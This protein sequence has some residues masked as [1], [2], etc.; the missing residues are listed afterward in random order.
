MAIRV[1]IT[2]EFPLQRLFTIHVR[3]YTYMFPLA[4]ALMTEKTRAL[5][6]LVFDKVIEVLRTTVGNGAITIINMV[7]DYEFAILNA[8]S[9]AFPRGTPRGCW[10]HFGQAIFRKVTRENL[11][12]AYI[13]RPN[14]KKIIM[15]LIA[16]ALLPAAQ[17]HDGFMHIQRESVALLVEETP[18]IR[19]KIQIIFEYM[20]RY[21]FDIVTPERFS[22][23]GQSSRTNNEV[24]CFHRWFNARCGKYHQSFWTFIEYLLGEN[25]VNVDTIFLFAIFLV[26]FTFS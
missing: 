9:A 3:A 13:N 26:V 10:F 6:T 7:S 12:E 5:Y 11:K 23:Y 1:S 4:Y 17:A 16:L 19:A 24:E 8:M 18:E 20:Q 22:V 21:W 14:V 2:E 15:M 25:G